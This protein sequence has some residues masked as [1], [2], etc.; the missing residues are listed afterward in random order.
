VHLRSGTLHLTTLE[1]TLLERDGRIDERAA[2]K[3]RQ[4]ID[5]HIRYDAQLVSLPAATD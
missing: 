5:V 1:I 2:E 4:N 3:L